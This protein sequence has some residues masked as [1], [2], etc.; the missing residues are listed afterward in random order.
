MGS[1]TGCDWTGTHTW[2]LENFSQFGDGDTTRSPVFE[3]GGY[4]WSLLFFAYGY[5]PD[6]ETNYV[7]LFLEL[8]YARYTPVINCPS[9]YYQLSAINQS[10]PEKTY[11]GRIG[12]NMFTSYL[13]NRGHNMIETSTAQDLDS[14]FVVDDCLLFEVKIFIVEDQ[15]ICNLNPVKL[16]GSATSQST[17]QDLIFLDVGGQPFKMAKSTVERFPESL[18]CKMVEKFPELVEKREELYIDR[19]PKAFPWIREIYRDGDFQ[20]TLPDMPFELLEKELDFYQLPLAE[21]LGIKQKPNTKSD[22]GFR[23]PMVELFHEIMAEIEACNLHDHERH[24]VF[25]Y[26]RQMGNRK[27]GMRRVFVVPPDNLL[28][29]QCIHYRGHETFDKAIH[30]APEEV[31][32]RNCTGLTIIHHPATGEKFRV[33]YIED[34]ERINLLN[35]EASKFGMTVSHDR[36]TRDTAGENVKIALL[37]IEYA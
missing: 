33:V 19:N 37:K 36:F 10:D 26:Y 14:G 28:R 25:V 16:Q 30:A 24:Y 20:H 3:I 11:R 22:K 15:S 27:E 7:S 5:M 12:H 2:R 1:W 8:P 21:E 29:N 13:P 6:M 9:A 18:L 4:T 35:E 34:D 32:G 17:R 31:S 23:P